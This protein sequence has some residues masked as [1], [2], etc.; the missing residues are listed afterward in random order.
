MTISKSNSLV[1]TSTIVKFIPK[2]K[3]KFHFGQKV[4]MRQPVKELD[5]FERSLHYVDDMIV[6]NTIPR[7]PSGFEYLIKSKQLEGSLTIPEKELRTYIRW[8]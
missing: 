4:S 2:G 8:D 3:P 7:Y 6:I 5:I 1:T